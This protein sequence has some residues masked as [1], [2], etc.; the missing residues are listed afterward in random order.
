M[1]LNTGIST[2][3]PLQ[4]AIAGI[5]G[6]GRVRLV[7]CYEGSQYRAAAQALEKQVCGSHADELE[8]SIMLAIA[9]ECVNME[10]AEACVE[11]MA[12]GPLNRTDPQAANYSPSG[13]YGDPRLATR[14]KGE[15]L[16]GAML[17]DIVDSI[18]ALRGQA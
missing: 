5:G 2:T 12:Q 7:N 9:P 1:V 13:V 3:A 17:R 4:E 6:E 18:E 10:R 11:P 16:V 14:E 15:Q 8:T